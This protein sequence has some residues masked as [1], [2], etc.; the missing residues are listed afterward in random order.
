MW[1][2]AWLLRTTHNLANK[3]YIYHRDPESMHQSVVEKIAP[4][5]QSHPK[6]LKMLSNTLSVDD[7]SLAVEDF[8]GWAYKNQLWIAAWLLKSPHWLKFWEALGVGFIEIWSIVW[9][10]RDGNQKPRI[11]RYP[12]A[13]KLTVVNQ[14]WLPSPW[15]RTIYEQFKTI[16]SQG[17]LPNIPLRGNFTNTPDSRMLHHEKVDDIKIS[18]SRMYDFVKVIV[19]N[20]SCPNTWENLQEE[21]AALLAPLVEANKRIAEERGEEPKPMVAKIW[22]ITSGDSHITQFYPADNTIDQTKHMLDVFMNMGI[23]WVSATNT[24]KE[25]TYL[26]KASPLDSSWKPRWGMSGEALHERAVLTVEAIKHHVW[27]QLKIVGLGWI[28]CWPNPA[29]WVASAKNMINA[30]ADMLQMYTWIVNN[31]TSPHYI[32]K[33]LAQSHTK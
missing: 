8:L 12:N 25:H 29:A 22:P 10:K 14:M 1:L 3:A 28:G 11:W 21:V 5:I 4:T 16:A 26:P 13:G 19:I 27:D 18:M 23:Q 6:I 7:P 20:V 30:W 9:K 33:W 2:W 32:L 24:A 15:A 31:M 17:E